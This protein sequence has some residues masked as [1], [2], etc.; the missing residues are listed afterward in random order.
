MI[1]M[2]MTTIT[3]DFLGQIGADEREKLLKLGRHSSFR[4]GEFVFRLG[5]RGDSVYFLLAGRL[6]FFRLAPNGREVI[7]WFCFPGEVFGMTEVND[8]KGRRV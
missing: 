4:K 7:L 8:V 2:Q 5:D 3:A 1:H 6:K